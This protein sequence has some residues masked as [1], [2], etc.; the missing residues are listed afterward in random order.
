MGTMTSET[1]SEAIVRL[2]IGDWRGDSW[3]VTASF[4]ALE[5]SSQGSLGGGSVAAEGV[6]GEP[7]EGTLSRSGQISITES[8]ALSERLSDNLDPSALFTELLAPLPPDGDAPMNSWPVASTVVSDAAVRLVS[9]FE[10]MARLAGDTLWG[11][12]SAK[13]IVAE[14]TLEIEGNG[15]PAGMP[16][17]MHLMLSGESTRLYVWDAQRGVMLASLITGEADGTLSL[18]GMD[19]SIPA[20]FNTRQEVTLQR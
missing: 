15:S 6:I 18:V 19:L 12:I 13:L 4:E 20:R 14:G 17:E 5:V 10:G 11:G 16:A 3:P 2:E 9:V 8:P 7:F 1:S